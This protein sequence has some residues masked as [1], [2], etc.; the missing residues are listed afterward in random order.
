MAEAP[1]NGTFVGGTYPS[2]AYGY[3][4]SF[5]HAAEASHG[6]HQISIVQ[7]GQINGDSSIKVNPCLSGEPGMGGRRTE[8]LRVP[9]LRHLVHERTGCNGDVAC[10]A[11]YLGALNVYNVAANAGAGFEHDPPAARDRPDLRAN[12]FFSATSA[13]N[14]EFVQGAR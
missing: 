6:D 12:S 5:A 10:N 14:A 9:D 13:R 11:G 2:G 1:G 8:P 4:I 7:V 3:D